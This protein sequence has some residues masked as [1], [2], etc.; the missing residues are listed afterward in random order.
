M[1]KGMGFALLIYL[2]ILKMKELGH[3]ETN[4]FIFIGYLIKITKAP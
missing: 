4:Y 2:I 1:Y 3:T